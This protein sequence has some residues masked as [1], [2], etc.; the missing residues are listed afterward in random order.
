MKNLNTPEDAS[1]D[2]VKKF[3]RELGPKQYSHE[4]LK[5]F[6]SDFSES[7][8][9]GS[10]GYGDV[11][12][13]QFPGGIDIAVKVLAKKDVV[14]ETFM[15]EVSTMAK[16][17]HQNLIKL[18][19]YC[20][21]LNIKALVYE[22]M[23]NGSLDKILYEN[24][25]SNIKWGKL[26]DIAIQTARGLIYLHHDC[27]ERIVHY[28]I[29]AGNVL[30]DKNL[31][32]KITDFGLAKIMKNDVSLVPLTRIRGTHGYNAPE[33]WMPASRVSYKCDVFSFGM[34]LFEVLGKRRNG[35]GENW[36][37]GQVWKEFKNG[38]LE[39]FIKDCYI[40]EKDREK[41]KILSMVALWCA[42]Y[43]PTIRPSMTEVVLMLEKR[44]PVGTPPYPFQFGQSWTFSI[45]QEEIPE[46]YSEFEESVHGGTPPLYSDMTTTPD[47]ATEIL[48]MPRNSNDDSDSTP[49]L[50][51]EE[52]KMDEEKE[53]IHDEMGLSSLFSSV[54][55]EFAWGSTSRERPLQSTRLNAEEEKTDNTTEEFHDEMGLSSLFSVAGVNDIAPTE[56]FHDEMGLRSLFS[57]A[58]IPKVAYSSDAASSAT[59]AAWKR[60][61][62]E[63]DIAATEEFDDE[64]GLRSLFS[65][66]GIPKVAYSSDAASSATPAAWKRE[67]KEDVSIRKGF[68]LRSSIRGLVRK[69]F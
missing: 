52:E 68:S 44:I 5:S 59:P 6:T 49:L 69:V 15:A 57:I 43:T 48:E 50:A 22:Y 21:D 45:L 46:V 34:M 54:G 1:S 11:Y 36:F 25:H 51:K 47:N 13:G 39:Q 61:V 2:L 38:R 64:M 37:P 9:V 10:G 63:D 28:D 20:F 26:Y 67:V 31:S 41:A 33:T 17:N 29:K 55:D 58:G 56:E 60:E 23:E 14:E 3:L 18:Y 7:N 42:Q 40:P 30:L 19:G 8:L 27:N 24:H 62:K 16:A 65:I 66:P 32:P 12:K 53:E 35:E 4:N